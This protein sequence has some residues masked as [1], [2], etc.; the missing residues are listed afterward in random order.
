MLTKNIRCKSCDCILW[1]SYARAIGLCPECETE[2]EEL[3]DLED[4]LEKLLK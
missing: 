3:L 2:D 1:S 4:E